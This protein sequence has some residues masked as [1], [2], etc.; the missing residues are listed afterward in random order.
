MIEFKWAR[1]EDFYKFTK[2][3]P[4]WPLVIKAVSLLTRKENALELGSGAGRDT[5]YLLEQGFHVT[6]V[7]KDPHA[8]AILAELPQHKLRLVQSAFEDF[9]FEPETYDLV[10]AQFALPF[11]PKEYFSEVFARV[12]GALRPEGIFAGQ[13]FGIHDEWNTPGN[14]MTFL[15]REQAEDLL[16]GM[17]VIEFRE[18]DVDGHVADG[19][20]KHWHVFHMSAQRVSSEGNSLEA[21]VI[22]KGALA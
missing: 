5:A 6:G 4:P 10:S 15:A 20:P 3:K 12:K 7:D 13:L 19:T 16:T 14:H 1:W 22:D 21:S 11:T 2:G 9:K 18:E 17:K 8:M